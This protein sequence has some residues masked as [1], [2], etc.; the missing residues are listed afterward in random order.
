MTPRE[1]DLIMGGAFIYQR[2][3][4]SR[5]ATWTNMEK[6][7]VRHIARSGPLT[8]EDLAT[9]SSEVLARINEGLA[10]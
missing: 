1:L 10:A 3:D 4:G 9:P 8:A 7:G 5:Y 6:F 2:A